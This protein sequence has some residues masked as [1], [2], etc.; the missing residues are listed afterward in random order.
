MDFVTKK[1]I[2]A[3]ILPVPI[4][5][6]L[7]VIGGI[8]LIFSHHQ[9][10]GKFFVIL[11]T[12]ILIAF[13]TPYIP[14]H[15]LHYLESQYQPLNTIPKDTNQVVVLGAGNSG[16]SRYPAN[17][18]LSSASLSR[19]IEGIRI[20][21]QIPNCK[22]V[23]SGGRIFGSQ[24]DSAVMNNVAAMLG[25]RPQD[26]VMEAGSRDTFNEAV[27]LKKMIGDKPFVLVTSAYHMPRAIALFQQQGMQPIAA[28]TQLLIKKKGYGLKQYLPNSTYLVYSDI[29]IHE[30]LGM[31]WG[32]ISG[33]L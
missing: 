28:P 32:R 1:I 24:P 10:V 21:K 7:L 4:I 26:I 3:F 6:F 9:G 2:S 19:L 30:Y 8:F 33:L 13:S 23:L 17:E 18:K 31:L 29:A 25:V 5:V 22:L 15:L 11:A 20:Y 14:T 12:L 27:Y 16:D